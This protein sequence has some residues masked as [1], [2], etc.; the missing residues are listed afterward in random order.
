MITLSLLKFKSYN[1]FH[2]LLQLNF[3]CRRS[4]C[5]CAWIY[6]VIQHLKLPDRCILFSYMRSESNQKLSLLLD[7]EHNTSTLRD[8]KLKFRLMLHLIVIHFLSYHTT[9]WCGEIQ[10]D[11][12]YFSESFD[13]YLS[14]C[15]LAFLTWHW[16]TNTGIWLQS[17]SVASKCK[18][19]VY[20]C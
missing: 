8:T 16:W 6:I 14:C 10:Q 7:S 13:I 9:G 2:D 19:L 3:K 18:A 11:W 20:T 5:I 15:K 17:A 4:Y 12:N 1:S